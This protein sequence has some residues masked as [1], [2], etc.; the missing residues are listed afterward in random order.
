MGEHIVAPGGAH[1]C[2]VWQTAMH[3]L[4][5]DHDFGELPGLVDAMLV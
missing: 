3:A 1:P 4:G 2:N 5:V